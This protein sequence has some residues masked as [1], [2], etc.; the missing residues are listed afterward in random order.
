M[1]SQ[2]VEQARH[3]RLE[4]RGVDVEPGDHGREVAMLTLELVDLVDEL[5]CDAEGAED[6]VLL[7]LDVPFEVGDEA[8][9]ARHRSGRIPCAQVLSDAVCLVDEGGVLVH[10]LADRRHLLGIRSTH[11]PQPTRSQ[12]RRGRWLPSWASSRLR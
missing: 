12:P 3:L 5:A 1:H 11:T 7:A 10:Q 4:V 2:V 6:P 8:G 9:Q